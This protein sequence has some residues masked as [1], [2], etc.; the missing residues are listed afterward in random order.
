MGYVLKGKVSG[1]TPAEKWFL[2]THPFMIGK[3][4][5]N[6]EKALAESRKRYSGAGQHNGFGD[7]FRHCYWSALLARDIGKSAATKITTAHEGYSE[8]PSSERAMDLHNNG[9]GV[10]IGQMNSKASDAKL[11]GLC[12]KA[13]T[14]GKLLTAP[15]AKGKPYKY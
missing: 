2:I 1:L 3:I 12:S 15:P 9:V 8:N 4:K 10:S 6:A 11:A 5:E 14:S 13:L 7:A